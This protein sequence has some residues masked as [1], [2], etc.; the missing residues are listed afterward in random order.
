MDRTDIQIINLLQNNARMS[1]KEIAQ[2]VSLSAPAAAERITRLKESGVIESFTADI[3]DAKM[4]NSVSA[5]VLMNVPPAQYESFCAF[6]EKEP[7]I[8][9]HHHIIG[10][11]NALL[12]VRV[13]DTN[14]LEAL[15]SRTREF[16]LSNTS[17]LLSTYFTKKDYPES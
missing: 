14:A 6:C 1:T 9:E 2:T 13:A 8:V 3:N 10:I 11:N 12:R 4:G 17:V 15:L 7:S 5:Y 16:G